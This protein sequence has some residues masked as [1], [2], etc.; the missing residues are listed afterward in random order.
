MLHPGARNTVSSRSYSVVGFM[1]DFMRGYMVGFMRGL[2]G[3][4]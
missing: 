4:Y 3:N 1:I 2:K